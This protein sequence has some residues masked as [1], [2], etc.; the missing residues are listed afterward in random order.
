M[1][2]GIEALISLEK[3]GTV[4]EAA[5]RLRLTQ[6]A[7][8]KRIKALEVQLGYALVEVDGRKLRLLPAAMAVLGKARPLLAELHGLKHMQEP[9]RQQFTLGMADSIASSW[10]PRLLK[11]AQ[12]KLQELQLEVHVHRS[13]LILERLRLGHY[14]LGIVTGR[15]QGTDLVWTRLAEE[16]MVLVG[17]SQRG[18]GK[19]Q[20][21][22]TIETMSATWREIG[23][24]ALNHPRLSGQ[25]F[26]FL[27]SFAAAAQMAKAG[28]G[29]ALVP[30]GTATALGFREPEITRLSP[31][32]PRQINL[33]ARKSVHNLRSIAELNMALLSIAGKLV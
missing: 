21:I 4:S 33:V 17:Q 12:G 19:S 9:T 2:D 5:V 18:S 11:Q 24:R 31:R 8:S 32:L 13:L 16:P 26:T 20:P 3:T 1:L 25:R 7:V 15:P 27:E 22:L 10:G 29:R 14:E 6:S 28:F 23:T 30:L